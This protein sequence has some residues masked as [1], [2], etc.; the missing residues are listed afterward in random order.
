MTTTEYAL[1]TDG[2]GK[3]YGRTWA[4]RD[5]TLSVPTGRVIA[6][7]GPNGAGKSTLLRLVVGLLAPTSGTVEVLGRS[8]AANTPQV[9]SRTG[10]LAQE[11][12]LYKHFT[13]ADLLHMGRSLTT[14]AST[15]TSPNGGWRNWTSRWTSRPVPS[16]AVNKPRWHWHWRWPSGRTCSSWTSRWPASTP[17]PDS[18]SSR[19]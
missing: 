10:F 4:L 8:P 9:L 7:V 14:C 3:R 19:P 5:C 6:L 1:R 12:P 16:P 2:L 17:S 13:V 18:N 15:K 11:H